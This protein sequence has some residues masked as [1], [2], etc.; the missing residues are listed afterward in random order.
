M[1]ILFMGTPEFAVPSLQ[2]LLEHSY[3]IG[4]VVTTPDKPRGRGQQVSFTPVKEFALQHHLKILQPGNLKNPA[5]IAAIQQLNPDLIVVVAFRILPKEVYTIPK[6]GSFNLHASLLPK[7]RGAAPINWAIINGE[8]ETGVTTFFLKEKVDTGAIIFQSVVSIRPDETA[9][10]L[11]DELSNVGARAVLKTVQLIE[12]GNVKE[13]FQDDSPAIPAPKIY[14]DDCHID[15]KKPCQQVYDFIRGLSPYPA[16]WA[17]HNGKTIKFYRAEMVD[18]HPAKPGI[19]H[20]QANNELHIGTGKGAIS[21]L[22][23]Q[24]EGK[25][26]LNIEEFLRGYPIKDG[27]VFE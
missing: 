13:K 17:I 16:A 2:V 15:W 22:E 18:S 10:E 6:F 9:G 5:F 20:K 27:E 3:E 14:T 7:Y 1:R 21:V 8:K 26:R 25:R 23:I 4:A 19:V 12:L 11:H 24:Q